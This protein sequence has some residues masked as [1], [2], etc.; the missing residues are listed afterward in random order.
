MPDISRRFF[1]G[2]LIAT[3]AVVSATS[4]MPLRGYIL[5][6]ASRRWMAAYIPATDQL[7]I[8]CDI[9]YGNLVTTGQPLTPID[10]FVG[11]GVW[12]IDDSTQKHFEH[13][14]ARGIDK[15]NKLALDNIG[16]QYHIDFDWRQHLSSDHEM[17]ILGD[18]NHPIAGIVDK[19]Q[20]KIIRL[21]PQNHA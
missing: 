16:H 5:P 19:P 13:R 12:T 9:A 17:L 6:K 14:L 2:A 1:L 11:K 20:S 18:K 21:A 7:I 3:P 10:E 4:L 15:A 8:R